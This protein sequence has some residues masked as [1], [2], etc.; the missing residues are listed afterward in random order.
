MFKNRY[1]RTIMLS[2][3]LLN[4]GIW[5]RNFAILL[6]VTEMT[7]NDPKYVSL[8]SVAEFAPI[9]VFSIIGG[10]FADRWKPRRTMIWCDSLSAVSMLMI[11]PV[12]VYGSWSALFF[13]TLVSSILSQFS[14]PSA[15]KIFKQHVPEQQLQGLMAMLQ[16]LVAFFTV[17][18][19]V[20]GAFVYQQFGIEVS[21]G[22][23]G[24]LMIGSASIL[25]TLPKDS[26]HVGGS[27]SDF[28][29]ELK[30]GLRYVG[31]NRELRTLGMTFV[32]TGLAAGMIQPL[33]IF[34]TMENLGLDKSYLQ[35]LLMVNGAAMLV[36]GAVIMSL[37]KR[38][39]PQWILALGLG[40]STCTA[41]GVGW[42]T[43]FPLTLGLEVISGFFYPFIMIGIN[44]LIIK[45][46]EGAFIGRVSGVMTPM[47][48]GM[49]V[50]GM[51][52]SG[53]FKDVFSLFAV[54]TT[55]G[56]LFF[57][58]AMVLIPIFKEKSKDVKRHE[59]SAS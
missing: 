54:Y 37:A 3:V 8:I 57:I 44:T 25:A 23:M 14:Q 26:A 15:M 21:L 56:I 5:V 59:A 6:Y 17:I 16:S 49:M 36:G 13:A 42:S 55:S 29:M 20:V 58:G 4:L 35:W 45:N 52:I 40:V 30:A 34:V 9:F 1:V 47:F 38:M 51:S 53:I 12:M 43:S 22:V 19:P 7:N 50:I 33:L 31:R 39:K 46:T 10:T 27:H 18:G 48:M 2:R 32:V 28:M 41:I 24:V 11:I